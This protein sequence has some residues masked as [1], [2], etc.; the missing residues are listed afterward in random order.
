[1]T[2]AAHRRREHRHGGRPRLDRHH[3][4]AVDLFRIDGTGILAFSARDEGAT[5]YPLYWTGRY[6]GDTFTPDGLHRL[7]Y[8][9]CYL[10]APQSTRDAL[11]RRILFGRLQ[12]GR[13]EDARAEAGW[14]GVMSLPSVVTLG[15]DGRLAQAP[16]PELARLRREAVRTGA[17]TVTDGTYLR[18]G[19]VRGDQLDVETTLLNS[20]PRPV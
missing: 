11:G 4:G 1:M 10:Y 17:F 15:A 3:V 16:V 12:E 9:Q 18:L 7:D 6:E 20:C 8:G 2:P 5:R 19:E 14:C 13:D